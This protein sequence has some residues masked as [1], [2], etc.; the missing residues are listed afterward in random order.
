M[1]LIKAVTKDRISIISKIKSAEI[2]NMNTIDIIV[3]SMRIT[4]NLTPEQAQTFLEKRDMTVVEILKDHGWPEGPVENVNV[5]YEVEELD[6]VDP[7]NAEFKLGL[8]R[9]ESLNKTLKIFANRVMAR[10]TTKTLV[11]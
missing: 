9:I 5:E 3:G 1:R 2:T 4:Y 8:I 7:E 10:L 6:F 11:E